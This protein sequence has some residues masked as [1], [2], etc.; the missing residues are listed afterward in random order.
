VLVKAG[1]LQAAAAL[2][3]AVPGVEVHASSAEG[4]IVVTCEAAGSR[5]LLDRVDAIR[6]IEGV[7]SATLVYQHS[8]PLSSMLEEICHADHAS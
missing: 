7:L 1:H 6:G 5:E 4:K 3:S 2:V 8:E